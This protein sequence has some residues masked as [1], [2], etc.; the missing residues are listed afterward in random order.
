MDAPLVVVTHTTTVALGLMRSSV[1]AAA[2]LGATPWRYT[3]YSLAYI[4]F[5]SHTN[6]F[7]WTHANLNAHILFVSHRVRA[8]TAKAGITAPTPADSSNS[9]R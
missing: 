5:V 3:D 1:P 4:L 2:N 8:T 7:E 6:Y 9:L